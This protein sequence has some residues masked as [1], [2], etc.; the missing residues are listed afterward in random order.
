MRIVF[1][2]IALA[3]AISCTPPGNKAADAGK[4][5]A[6]DAVKDAGVKKE[7]APKADAGKADKT[8]PTKTAKAK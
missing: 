2:L 6:S 4:P 8:K 1:A 5:K 7:V 3:L